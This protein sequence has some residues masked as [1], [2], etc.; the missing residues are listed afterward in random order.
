MLN[1]L[2]SLYDID[3]LRPLVDQIGRMSGRACERH[4]RSFRIVADHANAACHLAADGVEPANIERGYVLRRLI[5]AG[6]SPRP[7]PRH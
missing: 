5:R 6:C 1:G 4:A 7:P 2:D 3:T